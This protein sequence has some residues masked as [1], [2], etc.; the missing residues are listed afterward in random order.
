VQLHIME[1]YNRHMGYIN[2]SDHMANS[3]LMSQGTFE[4]TKKLFFRLLDL[5][6]LNSWIHLHVRLNIPTKISGCFWW[7][8]W[9]KNLAKAKT[10]P[11]LNWLEDQ[12]RPQ[13]MFC[14]S[15]GQQ[16]HPP[17][18]T[19]VCVHLVAREKA[20]CI[21]APDVMWACVWGLVSQNITTE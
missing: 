2:D 9:L 18:S 17:K 7:A 20:Q 14:D 4:W 10:A 6:V 16:N 1:W 19:A 5:T 13:Q 12:G 21:S 8:I 15:T 3:Y 11:P